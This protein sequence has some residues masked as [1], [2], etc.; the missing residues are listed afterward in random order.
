MSISLASWK[1]QKAYRHI[2]GKNIVVIGIS[3]GHETG[4]LQVK[5]LIDAK[6]DGEGGHYCGEAI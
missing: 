5:K 1:Y 4:D 3:N 2:K 6:E